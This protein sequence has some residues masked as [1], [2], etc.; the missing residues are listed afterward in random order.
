VLVAGV[1][2]AAG[3]FFVHGLLDYFLIFTPTY[4]LFWLL[5]GL[6]GGTM[7]RAAAP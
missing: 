4:G 5:V 6:I 7:P 1:A 2:V 3:S